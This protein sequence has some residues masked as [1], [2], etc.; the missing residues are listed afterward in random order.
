MSP[1]VLKCLNVRLWIKDS[2]EIEKLLLTEM[3]CV[4]PP[5]CIVVS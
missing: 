3:L 2:N 1:S 5:G 4:V